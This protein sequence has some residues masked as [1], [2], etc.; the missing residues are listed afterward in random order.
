MD[1]PWDDP[2]L[3]T[4][5]DEEIEALVTFAG[6]SRARIGF[7]SLLADGRID[8][9]QPIELWI[10]AR[11]TYVFSLAELLGIG[12]ARELV[13]HG[14]KALSGPFRDE[15]NGGW[16]SAI[17]PYS[18]DE[19]APVP[20]ARKEAY[21]HAF[22]VLAASAAA[23][24]GHDGAR[25]LLHDALN[26][27]EEHWWD[28]S[29]GRV[30]DS[31]NVD[32]SRYSTYRGM[33]ANMHTVEAYLAAWETTGDRVWLDRARAILRWISELNSRGGG[34]LVEHFDDKWLPT[35]ELNADRP[36]DPFRPYGV[37][38]GHAFECSRLLLAAHAALENIGEKPGAWM[39]QAAKDLYERASKDGWAEDGVAGFVYTTDYDGRPVLRLRMHWVACE[40]ICAALA[41]GRHELADGNSEQALSCAHDF[42]T[43]LSWA[44]E[45]LHDAPGHW[46]HELA[47]EG[48]R[49]TVIWPGRPDAYHVIQMLLMART[50]P[51]V[52]FAASLVRCP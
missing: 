21:A 36:A 24:A 20:K 45:Y 25:N 3:I 19:A 15:V 13:D 30:R 41:M 43:W 27:Q 2:A 52:G 46:I 11:M 26:D 44:D 35:P 28:P 49:S 42:A 16:Y 5:F 31:A 33:N 12:G 48:G 50:R 29:W 37:T 10:T 23:Q 47:E 6:Q 9:G 8:L 51:G 17:V 40:A 38:P 14:L 39:S 34:R 7:G 32:F 22:V 18:D 1:M 4:S